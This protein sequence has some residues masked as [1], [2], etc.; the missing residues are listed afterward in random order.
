MIPVSRKLCLE[1]GIQYS[2]KGF[3]S[4]D[5]FA[6]HHPVMEAQVM[7]DT[8]YYLY[9]LG[10][11]LTL[12]YTLLQND[13]HRLQLGGGMIYSFLLRGGNDY[14][15]KQTQSGQYMEFEMKN[16]RIFKGLMQTKDTY[17]N[18]MSILDVGVR[19][20][21]S[22]TFRSQ[23]ILRLFHEQSLY[24]VYLK[25]TSAEQAVKLRY[26][27]IS[28]GFCIPRLKG[29]IPVSGISGNKNQL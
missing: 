17:Y 10:I 22:Y 7:F 19:L 6:V 16:N 2:K 29:S 20:Q 13:K 24:S 28:V 14:F 23:L 1:P 4:I 15:S 26:T 25:P 21:L 9:Y 3:R 11:P 5:Q 8:R 27:G 12:N 18:T